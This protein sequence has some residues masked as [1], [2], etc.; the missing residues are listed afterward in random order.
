VSLGSTL[1]T[2]KEQQTATLTLPGRIPA[3]AG[4][5]TFTFTS[6]T[7]VGPTKPATIP[8]QG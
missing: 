8:L 1:V 5:V 6:H 3:G 2:V 4:E 7:G